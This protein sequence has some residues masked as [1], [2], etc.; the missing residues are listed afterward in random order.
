MKPCSTFCLALLASA[1]SAQILPTSAFD[2]EVD[3]VNDVI[4]AS[5]TNNAEGNPRLEFRTGNG[6]G[7]VTPF[8][9]LFSVFGDQLRRVAEMTGPGSRGYFKTRHGM[10]ANGGG[11]QVNRYTVLFDV[12]HDASG[13]G[14]YSSL[15]N[16]NDTNGN[17]GDSF[18]LWDANGDARIGV[19]QS[20]GSSFDPKF[21][22]RIVVSVRTGTGFLGLGAEIKYYVDGVFKR[23]V[24]AALGGLVDGTYATY[25]GASD[26]SINVFGDDNE[27]NPLGVLLQLAFFDRVLSDQEIAGLG[28]VGTPF[29]QIVAPSS[30][31]VVLGRRDRGNVGSLL[32]AGDGDVY[33]TCR[34]VV[35]NNQV[36][37]IQVE[38]A[39]STQVRAFSS[40]RF[41]TVARFQTA[42]LY[43]QTL[44]LFDWQAN[45]YDPT[46]VSS[47]NMTSTFGVQTV[48][49]TGN[50]AR[51]VGTAG[52][53]RARFRVRPIGPTAL[54]IWC[55]E[56][57]AASWLVNR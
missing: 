39:G 1:A 18:L 4:A 21:W 52:A 27:E 2:F 43:R 11:S 5:T 17:D 46:D 37:P 53:L 23:S 26:R 45:R 15:F 8:R 25:A 51:Y 36:D 7:Q 28:P 29:A 34:F 48:A 19:E 16:C 20:Y 40:L 35:P 42:G 57:D 47:Q 54:P 44:E 31:T 24:T 9:F 41:Q 56:H 38:V 50:R 10:R 14:A 3:P 22:R 30:V 49:A 33:R 55:V 32:R 12:R 13:D 6:E